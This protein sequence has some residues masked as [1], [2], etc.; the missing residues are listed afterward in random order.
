M[1]FVNFHTQTL[2]VVEARW[3]RGGV[4]VQA[5]AKSRYMIYSFIVFIQGF[6]IPF[7]RDRDHL[8]HPVIPG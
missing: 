7:K 2:R 3:W 5:K 4:M 6:F 8:R 1:N